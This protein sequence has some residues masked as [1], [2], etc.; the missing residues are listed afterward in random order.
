[1][2][3][4]DTQDK[5]GL[6]FSIGFNFEGA[7]RCE[8]HDLLVEKGLEPATLVHPSAIISKD[9]VVGK[10]SQIMAGSVIGPDARIGRQC[11]INSRVGVDHDNLLEEGVE[12]SP[13]ATL[14]GHVTVEAYAWIAAGATVLPM[15]TIGTKALVGAGSLVNRDVPAETRVAGI[16]A[17]PLASG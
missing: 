8:M 5:T 13:G 14:C 4:I 7:L 12:I 16:P 15:V 17:K 6:G 10:G 3:W 1:M 2:A 11:I 9:A